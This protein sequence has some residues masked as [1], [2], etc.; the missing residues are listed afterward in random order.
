M[1]ENLKVGGGCKVAGMVEKLVSKKE[2][3][4]RLGVSVRSVDRLIAKGVL[5][6]IKILGAVR[7]RFS[8]VLLIMEGG[9]L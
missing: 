2:V 3:A 7:F 5:R 4:E 1:L 6:R 9:R 8:D